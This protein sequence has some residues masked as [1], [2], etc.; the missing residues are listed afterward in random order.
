MI[1][2]PEKRIYYL[3]QIRYHQLNP[4][5]QNSIIPLGTKPQSS[6]YFKANICL[7]DSPTP[8]RNA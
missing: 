5:V 6:Y 4:F 7:I 8:P 1:M 2:F 3:L